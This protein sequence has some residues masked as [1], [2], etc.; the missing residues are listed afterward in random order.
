MS[1]LLHALHEPK[2]DVDIDLEKD[3]GKRPPERPI[4]EE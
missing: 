2:E 4:I 1:S 3:K